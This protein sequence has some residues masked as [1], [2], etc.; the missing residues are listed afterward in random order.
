MTRKLICNLFVQEYLERSYGNFTSIQKYPPTSLPRTFN[1]RYG[2]AHDDR[3]G[4]GGFDKYSSNKTRKAIFSTSD[5]S[6]TEAA[7]GPHKISSVECFPVPQI[8]M[9]GDCGEGARSAA[10]GPFRV[11]HR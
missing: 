9:N 11:N 2:S 8:R 3:C 1:D 5:F 10:F 6:S 7:G 4:V